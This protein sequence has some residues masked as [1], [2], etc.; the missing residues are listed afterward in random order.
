MS[1]RAGEKLTKDEIIAIENILATGNR[2]ELIPTKDGVRIIKIIRHNQ[3]IP[4]QK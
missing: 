2:V 4:V 3:Q 1:K